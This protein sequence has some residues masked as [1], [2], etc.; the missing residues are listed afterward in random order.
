M[1][2][3]GNPTTGDILGLGLFALT[4]TFGLKL[5]EITKDDNPEF[6]NKIL[7]GTVDLI[8]KSMPV[9]EESNTENDNPIIIMEG[10][11]PQYTE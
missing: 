4:V 8:K 7:N 5:V 9:Y 10:Y 6:S 2:E 11:V 1:D 3:F